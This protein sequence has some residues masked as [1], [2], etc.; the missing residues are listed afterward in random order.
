MEE[1]E[2]VRPQGAGQQPALRAEHINRYTPALTCY[3][4]SEGRGEE[5][6]RDDMCGVVW[7]AG[8]GGPARTTPSQPFARLAEFI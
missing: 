2:G 5:E 4:F 3:E 7:S 6:E 1:W 8:G